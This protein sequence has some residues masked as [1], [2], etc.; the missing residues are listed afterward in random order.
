M[1]FNCQHDKSSDPESQPHTT[2][3]KGHSFSV[4]L[5]NFDAILEQ[6]T[7]LIAFLLNAF[8]EPENVVCAQA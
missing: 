3:V 4:S 7:I 2:A 5:E 1:M 6:L 8:F